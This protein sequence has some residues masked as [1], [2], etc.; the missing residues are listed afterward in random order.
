M[1]VGRYNVKL[2]DGTIK[3]FNVYQNEYGNHFIYL[4]KSYQQITRRKPYRGGWLW[5]LESEATK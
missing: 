3:K 5:E 4:N 2:G 1:K